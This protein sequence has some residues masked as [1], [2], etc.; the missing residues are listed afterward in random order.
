MIFEQRYIAFPDHFRALRKLPGY[1]WHEQEKQVYS[2]KSGVLK[3]LK[4]N[5]VNRY[6]SN[7]W[8]WTHNSFYYRFSINGKSKTLHE[9]WVIERIL[10]EHVIEV[11]QCVL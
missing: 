8:G 10:H 6:L 3:K 7:K 5:Q 4:K 11:Q 1:F 2:I 9:A